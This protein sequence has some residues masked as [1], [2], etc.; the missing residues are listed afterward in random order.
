MTH[1]EAW[2]AWV[3]LAALGCTGAKAVSHE[4]FVSPA[5]A[6]SAPAPDPGPEGKSFVAGVETVERGRQQRPQLGAVAQRHRLV[7]L[8]L[9]EATPDQPLLARHQETVVGRAH[10]LVARPE[11]DLP[12][13]PHTAVVEGVGLADAVEGGDL[14]DFV[15]EAVGPLPL[16]QVADADETV[17]GRDQRLA[18]HALADGAGDEGLH[19]R[20]H[21]D[22]GFHTQR[23]LADTAAR[24]GAVEHRQML[25]AQV[26]RAFQ[27]HGAADMQVGGVDVGAGKAQ[28]LQHVEVGRVERG[29]LQFQHLAAEFGPQSV[30]VEDKAQVEGGFQRSLDDADLTSADLSGM[31]WKGIA[32][33][34]HAMI[35][36]VR[37]APAGFVEWAL[38]HKAVKE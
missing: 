17:A 27:G 26:R 1:A 3:S 4:A 33:I 14:D 8:D 2:V 6:A 13:G 31:K 18:H 21:A 16:V 32:S 28:A 34:K 11:H 37:N 5:N 30:F 35:K 12:H 7:L 36:D 20:H 9:V 22:M 38:A 19:R 15:A 10:D 23:P 29:R 25:F 24:I